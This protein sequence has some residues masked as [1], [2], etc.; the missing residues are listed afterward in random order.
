[1]GRTERKVNADPTNTLHWYKDDFEVRLDPIPKSNSY[2]S[3]YNIQYID[4]WSMVD[5]RRTNL[6]IPITQKI[7]YHKDF[8]GLA[9]DFDSL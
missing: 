3:I 6:K 2:S 7:N 1:M 8:V 9:A 5:G 4:R